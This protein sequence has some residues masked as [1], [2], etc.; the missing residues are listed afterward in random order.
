MSRPGACGEQR[1]TRDFDPGFLA[2]AQSQAQLEATL[3]VGLKHELLAYDRLLNSM[4]AS[5]AQLTQGL[6]NHLQEE[7]PA[8][9]RD[10]LASIA[11]FENT[12]SE[13][14]LPVVRGRVPAQ[15][16]VTLEQGV[17]EAKH[18]VLLPKTWAWSRSRPRR[19]LPPMPLALPCVMG[20]LNTTRTRRSHTTEVDIDPHFV[21][22]P[23]PREQFQKSGQR[24]LKTRER[25]G[26]PP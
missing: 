15:G 12:R 9:A 16:H 10:R 2:C 21:E 24:L 23:N 13:I 18:S 14:S 20:K 7:L 26:S 19:W 5:F 22:T 3:R 6:V 17:R 8:H 11:V 25:N 4:H 1:A